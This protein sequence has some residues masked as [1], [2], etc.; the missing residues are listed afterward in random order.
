MR[1]LAMLNIPVW[2]RLWPGVLTAITIALAASFVAEHQGGPQLLYALFFGMAFNF[3][4]NGE[5]IRDGI[6]F[7]SRHVLRFGVAL[8]GARITAEQLAGLGAGSIAMVAGGVVATIL[9]GALV[10]RLLGRPGTEGI[11]TGGAVAICGASAALAIS[12]VL[13]KSD[14]NQRFTLFTVVGVTALSTVAMVVYP[15]L[16]KLFGLDAN[17]AAVFLGGTIHDVAQVVAAGYLISPE[18]GDGATF[19]KLFRVAML[20]PVVAV[21]SLLFRNGA[22]AGKKPPVLPGFL[23]GFAVLVAVNSLGLIPQPVTDAAS[24]LSRWCLVVAI[25]ALGV[26]TS[27]QQLAALGWRPVAMLAVNTVFLAALILSGLLMLR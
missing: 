13:P 27:F 21:V 16:V 5:K 14:E 12:A 18:V 10:G 19:V 7:A 26:K 9:F 17:A 6:E 3:A 20:L 11:L 22:P 2:V 24:G 4:A 25:A 23:V 1:A 15:S 8:L